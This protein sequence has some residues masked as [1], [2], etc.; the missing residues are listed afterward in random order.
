MSFKIISMLNNRLSSL[1][2]KK[3]TLE[4]KITESRRSLHCNEGDLVDINL[5]IQE[6]EQFLIRMP[7][8]SASCHEDGSVS[9]SED[10]WKQFVR[11]EK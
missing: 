8:S 9:F 4:E 10:Y 1:T 3:T 5:E 7:K 2:S 11:G 6:L